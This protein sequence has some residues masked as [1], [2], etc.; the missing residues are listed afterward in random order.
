MSQISVSQ[1]FANLEIKAAR[2]PRIYKFMERLAV[3]AQESEEAVQKLAQAERLIFGVT[4]KPEEPAPAAVVEQ[5]P[6]EV[7]D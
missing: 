2:L 3:A 1:Y 7:E 4:V 6:A 5:V